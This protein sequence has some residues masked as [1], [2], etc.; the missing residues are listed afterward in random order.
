[1]QVHITA[2]NR[3]QRTSKRT[4]KPFTSL[5]IK[6]QEHGERWLSGFNNAD[7]AHWE[8]GSIV[9]IEVEPKGE[10]LNFTIQKPEPAPQSQEHEVSNAELK[11][12]LTLKVI[13]Y[14]ERIAYNVSTLAGAN[15][16]AIDKAL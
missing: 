3:T 4:G 15:P 12:I 6:T 13:P 9:E 7:T 11:N 2:V 5:G 8:A 1:M 10:Y 16:S 14:L